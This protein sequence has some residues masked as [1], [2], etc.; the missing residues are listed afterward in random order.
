MIT[1]MEATCLGKAFQN[2]LLK[3]RYKGWEDEGEDLNNY[4]VAVRKRKFA[5]D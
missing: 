2:T 1:G 3:E 4:W 5:G